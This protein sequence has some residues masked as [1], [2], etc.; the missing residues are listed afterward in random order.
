MTSLAARGSFR[1]EL[2]DLTAPDASSRV[3]ALRPRVLWIETPSNPLLRITDIAT[4]AAAAHD[5][6]ALVVTD[7]T[8]LSP[9]LQTP[10]EHGADVVVHSTTKYLNGHSDVVGGAIVARDV[11][12]AEEIGWWANCLGV[13]GSPFDSFL[14]QRGVRTLHARMRVHEANAREIVELLASHP[15]VAAVYHPSLPTHTGHEVA[16][17]QQRGFGAMASFELRG[18]VEA[19]ERFVDGLEC[20]SLA[21]SLGGVESLVAHP[22]SMT[23]ASMDAAARRHAGISDSLLRLS[24]GV[25]DIADLL[26]DLECALQRAYGSGTRAGSEAATIPARIPHDA[27]RFEAPL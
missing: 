13:T 2:L 24:V 8:F 12:V 10:I 25:E 5:V 26:V 14:T 22:P 27:V 3:R 9:V 19:V 1:L 4:L 6:G 11:A 15:A 18:G 21:E 7:N 23:H 16:R 17:C 20:F